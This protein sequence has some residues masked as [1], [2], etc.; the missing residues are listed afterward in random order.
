MIRRLLM[1]IMI[2]GTFSVPAHAQI[3]AAYVNATL[4][5]GLTNAGDAKE[6]PFLLTFTLQPGWYMYW[7]TPGDSGL[8]PQFDHT[9]SVNVK[10]MSIGWP[11]PQRFEQDDMFSFGYEN[12]V[13]MPVT[14]TPA[15]PGKATTLALDISL[16]VC[17]KICVPQNISVKADVPEGTAMMSDVSERIK[18][19]TASL[20]VKGGGGDDFRL[21]TAVLGKGA[22]ILTM[23]S[24]DGFE[25]TDIFVESD[26]IALVAKPQI[27]QD[28]G[29]KQAA[30]FRIEAPS[31]TEDLTALLLGKTIT[32]TAVKGDKAVEKNFSF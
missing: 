16:I 10:D 6:I 19:R 21:D 14:V 13:S 2:M 29:N 28:A 30:I 4:Q 27:E 20:P 15:E 12:E 1:V 31:G 23:F 26:Q 25:G 3:P 5:A 24:K 22:V 9:K 17:N 32:V 11:A 18:K 7:R 8:A